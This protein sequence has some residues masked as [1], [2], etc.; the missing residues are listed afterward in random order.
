MPKHSPLKMWQRC[1]LMIG[2][3]ALVIGQ[4]AQLPA[5][6]FTQQD[7]MDNLQKQEELKG[8]IEATQ[9]KE[10]SLKAQIAQMDNQIALNEMELSDTQGQI[11]STQSLLEDV[12]S[13]IDDLSEKLGRLNDTIGQMQDAAEERIRAAYRHSRTPQFSVL[14]SASDF[15]EA[16]RNL[17]YLKQMEE[18][19]NKV[20]AEIN[21][22][23]DNYNAQKENLSKLQREKEQLAAQLEEKEAAAQTQQQ[24]LNQAKANKDALLARTKGDESV[25]QRL[26]QQAEAEAAAMASAHS[27]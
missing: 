20:L 12:A 18:A 24:E 10:H 4:A 23:L 11:Q 6:A 17:A 25:Y 8:K 27:A 9:S 5:M 14:I 22:N 2:T 7:Y 1:G 3:M 16:M 19:D 26:L 21:E 15:E 13:D